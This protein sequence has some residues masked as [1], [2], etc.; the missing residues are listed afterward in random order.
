MK[1]FEVNLFSL[2]EYMCLILKSW[3]INILHKKRFQGQL[4]IL[5][6]PSPPSTEIILLK[7]DV[8]LFFKMPLKFRNFPTFTFDAIDEISQEFP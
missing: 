3:K 5:V 1:Y 7:Y 4:Y 8:R 6:L 2:K